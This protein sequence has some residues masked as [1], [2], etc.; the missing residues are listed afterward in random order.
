[1]GENGRQGE[2]RGHSSEFRPNELLA[3][4]AFT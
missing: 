2:F 4:H 1:V 3:W